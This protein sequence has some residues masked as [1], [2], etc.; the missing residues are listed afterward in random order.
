[1]PNPRIEGRDIAKDENQG[2]ALLERAAR[3][4]F[5]QAEFQMGERTYGDGNNAAKY[6]DAYLWFALAQR[7]GAEKAD[8]RVSE[9]ETRMTPDQLSEAQ[10]RLERWPATPP[11]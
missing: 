4:G 5:P 3:S 2:M 1:L 9:L 10:K 6:V 8:A 7:S 11:K